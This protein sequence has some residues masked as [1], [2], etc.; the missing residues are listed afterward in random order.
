MAAKLALGDAYYIDRSYLLE[1][2]PDSVEGATWIMTANDDK[3]ATLDSFLSFEV[4]R[5]VRVYV[6]YDNR[7]QSLPNWMAS[8]RPVGTGVDVTDGG[9]SP[10]NL[11]EKDFVAGVVTLGGNRAAG[12]SAADSNYV[13][14]VEGR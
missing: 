10:L 6:G 13:V 4:D 5:P 9:A 12:A 14:L 3:Y 2:I 11:F 7:A 1:N 8:F